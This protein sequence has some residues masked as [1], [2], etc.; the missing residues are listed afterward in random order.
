M[1]TKI[2]LLALLLSF[3]SVNFISAQGFPPPAEGNA[4]VYFTRVSGYGGAVSFEYFDNDKYIG[5]FKGKNYMRY[6]CA[7][8]E[9]LLWAS[10]ENKEFITCDLKAGESYIVVIDVIMGAMKARVG[11]NPIDPND[12]EE[13]E[14]MERAIKLINDK[15]PV[16]TPQEKIDKKQKKLA[17]FIPEKLEMYETKWKNE[18][19]F[20]HVSAEMAIP[21]D[22]MK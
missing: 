15:A 16:V 3:V 21:A 4:V 17:K 8:G 1:K 2:T 22:K 20:K 10:S 5:I 6:E 14:V 19:N 7:G 12:A 11:M 18:K 9:Q 13:A